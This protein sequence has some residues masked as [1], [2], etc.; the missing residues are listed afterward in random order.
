METGKC[1]Y[2]VSIIAIET[3]DEIGSSQIEVL[4]LHA[5][6]LGD[7]IMGSCTYPTTGQVPVGG[8]HTGQLQWAFSRLWEWGA[9]YSFGVHVQR[10]PVWT[11]DRLHWYFKLNIWADTSQILKYF[12]ASRGVTSLN[13]CLMSDKARRLFSTLIASKPAPLCLWNPNL[14]LLTWLTWYH[15]L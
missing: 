2:W 3:D 12:T 1:C 9:K 14:H 15:F 11:H 10:R 8:I 7:V 6:C 5:Q 4:V 13:P